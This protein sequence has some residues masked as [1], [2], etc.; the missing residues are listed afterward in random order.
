MWR[1]MLFLLATP[2]V[3][4]SVVATRTVPAEAIV[5]AEDI[6]L[7]AM[8]IPGALQNLDAAIGKSALV[9]ITPGQAVHDDDLA[10]SIL[11]ERNA[12]VP[13]AFRANGLEIRTEGR[14]LS[15]GKVGDVIDIMN[16]S[17]RLRL[18]GRIGPDGVVIV[19]SGS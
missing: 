5:T 9:Q 12:L 19:T 14:A 4:D 11:I 1:A 2:A 10:A 18:Q 6:T 17:S 16:L 7:V 13:L 3:A 8:D 15:A